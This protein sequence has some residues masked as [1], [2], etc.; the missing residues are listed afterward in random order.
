M[1]LRG[2]SAAIAVQRSEFS[3][4][5]ILNSLHSKPTKTSCARWPTGGLWEKICSVFYLKQVSEVLSG[6]ESTW[7]T[8][9]ALH[10]THYNEFCPVAASHQ[11]LVTQRSLLASGVC[12]LGFLAVNKQLKGK[13]KDMV[14]TRN[15]IVRIISYLF[16]FIFLWANCYKLTAASRSVF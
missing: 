6:L 13:S 16:V 7:K 2:L 8:C 9:Q 5:H 4:Q 10:L 14:I 11:L 12:S 1:E 15:S 3:S